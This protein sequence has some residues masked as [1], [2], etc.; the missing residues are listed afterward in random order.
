MK[1]VFTI[2]LFLIYSVPGW[3]QF[4]QNDSVWHVRYHQNRLTVEA[5]YENK[6]AEEINNMK[7]VPFV[8]HLYCNNWLGYQYIEG[9]GG[10]QLRRKKIIGKKIRHHTQYVDQGRKQ[11][12]YGIN[13]P[14][15]GK[16]KLVGLLPSS[17]TSKLNWTYI[18]ES[19][20]I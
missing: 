3:S 5:Y 15:P 17:D 14:N 20:S 11:V 9:R 10:N 8:Y 12:W 1:P 2:F 19:K 4:T 16:R 6:A 7:V 18:Q 13:Y